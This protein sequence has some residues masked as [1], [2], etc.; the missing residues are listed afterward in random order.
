MNHMPIWQKITLGFGM[1]LLL[2]LLAGG[3]AVKTLFTLE[4]GNTRLHSRLLPFSDVVLDLRQHILRVI[5]NLGDYLLTDNARY[6]DDVQQE[7]IFVRDLLHQLD[8]MVLTIPEFHHLAPRVRE[9]QRNAA[10]YTSLVHR[11]HDNY[12]YLRETGKRLYEVGNNSRQEGQNYI[13]GRISLLLQRTSL[14]SEE[15]AGTVEYTLRMRA[16]LWGINMLRD[17]FSAGM[18][19]QRMALPAERAPDLPETLLKGV[20]RLLA[21]EPIPEFQSM[22]K[23]IRAELAVM[24]DVQY[25]YVQ[26]WDRQNA[27]EKQRAARSADI[28]SQVKLLGDFS[29]IDINR[30]F[31]FHATDTERALRILLAAIGVIFLLGLAFAVALTRYITKPLLKSR[32]FALAASKGDLTHRLELPQKDEIGQMVQAMNDMVDALNA[33]ISEAYR[34]EQKALTAQAAA[35]AAN[36]VKGDFLDRMSH[37]LRTPMNAVIGLSHLCLQTRLDA[38]QR[39]YVSQILRSANNLLGILTEILDFSKGESG[40][41]VI[42]R[43]PF[44]LE[45]IMDNLRTALT[46][47]A[48]G[49]GL[50]MRC[51]MEGDIPRPLYGDPLR[52]TQVL[53]HIAGNA[54]K[55]TEAGSVD[56][57]ATSEKISGDEILLRFTIRDTG[58]GL[59]PQ[60][61]ETLFQPFVQAD[62][63]ITRRFGGT[64]LGLAF[65]RH[66]VTLMG[67]DVRVE[68]APARGSTFTV[69]VPLGLKGD[70][71]HPVLLPD[72]RV[73]LVED[74]DINQEIARELLVGMGMH[75]DVADDGQAA[76]EAVKSATYD[77]IFMDV[78]MPA[79]D[80]LEATRQIRAA[81]HTMPIIAMTAHAL[82]GDRETSLAAGMN[83]HLTK[84]LSPERLH[85][86][87]ADWLPC[88]DTGESTAA[89]DGS[90]LP[91]FMAPGQDMSPMP[92]DIRDADIP[93]P[94]ELPGINIEAGL[95]AVGGNGRLY[96]HLL[97]KFA[98]RYATAGN[99]MTAAL[100]HGDINTAVQLAHTIKG[101]AANLGAVSLAEAAGLLEKNLLRNPDDIAPCM[102]TLSACL[103]E[104]VA[105][106]NLLAGAFPPMAEDIRETAGQEPPT[107]KGKCRPANGPA[108]AALVRDVLDSME[109]D[110]NRA[111]EQARKIRRALRGTVLDCRGR[112]FA[113]AVDDFDME[114]VALEGEA[115][116]RSLA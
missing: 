17:N 72:A 30:Q 91:D 42:E 51:R 64:G 98:T 25:R 78:Q 43:L 93:L 40:E 84:P 109:T 89:S 105:A 106:A 112:A 26:L 10:V 60:Q 94:A 68:S 116:R 95:A 44:Q 67:G 46:P 45:D 79:M 69:R 85:R 104:A 27:L 86:M 39:R 11:S 82:R 8:R 16:L 48:D 114:T 56:I 92:Q 6:W 97:N 101:V 61:A 23:N 24:S 19:L 108:L 59:D 74:N 73:L 41:L 31:Q 107:G 66:L 5:G 62:G 21:I 12:R 57:M 65:S 103:T 115:L 32:D 80:G 50:H 83:D 38:R 90:T 47:R 1:L 36:R 4:A 99:D 7:L 35:E 18:G 100:Q 9:L 13:N 77:L 111:S 102:N 14:T 81:G 88:A 3:I 110:W 53:L 113:Q 33:K 87:L 22:L 75:V 34:N 58:I 49:K 63:S 20:D 15:I 71:E 96:A 28:V 2:V 55:F 52:L 37:E 54:V 29:R 70:E 76:V